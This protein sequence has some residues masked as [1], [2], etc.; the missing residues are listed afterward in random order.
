MIEKSNQVVGSLVD[1]GLERRVFVLLSL[2]MSLAL[3]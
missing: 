2:P 3:G 1:S